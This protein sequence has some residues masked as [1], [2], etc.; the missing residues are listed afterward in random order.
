[1]PAALPEGNVPVPLDGAVP[2]EAVGAVAEAAFSVYVHVP[3]CASR[4]GYC[5]FN[6]YTAAELP[7]VNLAGYP[8]LVGRELALAGRVLPG[9]GPV[10]T[11]FFGG[12][13]PSLLPPADVARTLRRIG[14]IFG[15]RE[16]AEVTLEANPETIDERRAAGYAAAG[17]TRVSLGMQSAVDHVLAVLDRVHTPGRAVAALED[18]RRAGIG[19]VSLDLIYGTPGETAGDW[20]T[21][22][23]VAL[24][25]EPDHLSGYALTVEPGTKLAARVRRGELAPPDPDVLA[26]R[27]LAADAAAAAAGLTWYEVSNW[28][29]TPA[30]RCR[31]N[32]GYWR[33]GAWWG[34]GPGA[35]SHL[36][37]L[38]WWN[39]R[40]PAS[41][42]DRLRAGR[43]PAAG[44]EVLDEETRR[45]EEVM[46]RVRLAEGLP[47]RSLS[48]GGMAAA[49]QV[50]ADGLLQPAGDRLVLTPRGRLLGDAVVRAITD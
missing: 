2:P 25:A 7:G 31:H 46:L 19:Q 39:L 47:R 6:T 45:F 8:E 4:C 21:S 26:D 36:P 44:R 42:A 15:L 16:G 23:E 12:G 11:V 30:A 5:D 13:T 48:P 1:M 32:L 3:F 50:V 33:G 49:E 38:R 27:Y 24:G 10:H 9:A 37:G 43:S 40:H 20:A 14:D 17:V 41:Y 29:R 28:A 35:H 22:L 18:C 34:V